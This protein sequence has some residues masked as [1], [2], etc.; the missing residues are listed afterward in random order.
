MAAVVIWR[1]FG[2]VFPNSMTVVMETNMLPM[3]KLVDASSRRCV[4]LPG[5]MMKL[6]W[7]L[8]LLR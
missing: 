1:E 2:F 3:A 8:C 7:Q 4:I 5:D 6:V